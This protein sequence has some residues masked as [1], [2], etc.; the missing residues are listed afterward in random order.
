MSDNFAQTVK[1]QADIVRIIGDYIKL[2]KSGAQNYTGLCPFHKEK[3][4]SFSVNATHNYFYCF[5]CHEKGDVFTFVMKLENI[6]F[7]E[8]IRVVATKCGIPLPKRE[9]NSPDEVREAGIRRQLTDIH[10][11]ATQYFEAALKAPEAARAREYLTGRGVTAETIAKF[12]IGYAPDD[13]NHMREQLAKH[14]PDE[15]LRASGLFS[16]K[17]QNDGSQGQLYARFRKRITFPIANE[18]GKTIAFTARALDAED[19]KGRPIAKYLNSPETALYSKGQ[20]LFNLDKAKADIRALGFA[21]LVEGQMD[22]ISVYMA[23]IKGVL[24]TSGTAFTEMQIR[25]LS[26]FTKRVIVNFDPDTA[27]TAATEK[28]IALLTEEDFEV[29]IVTLEG[30]LDP[31]RFIREQGV[32]QY[33]A[34][35]RDAKR[36]SDYLIDRAREQFPTRTPEGKVKA[37]NFLLPHIRRM[38]SVRQREEFAVD[39]AQKLGISFV[40]SKELSDAASKKVESVSAHR[41]EPIDRNEEILLRV[42]VLPEN[43]PARIL[44][45]EQLTQHPEWYD[46]LSS[47]ALLESLANAPAPPNPLDAAPD[48]PSR[49][50]LARTLQNAENPDSASTNAQSMTELVENALETLKC[51]Q[52]ERRQRELRTLIAEADRHGDHEMLTKLTAEKLQ[53]DRKLREQ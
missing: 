39:A 26:R 7:P 11:A 45:V 15:V 52:L 31:D 27:G 48:E 6:S 51:R 10:E 28:S 4:G 47:A 8:A 22:C 18:Q 44:A 23:G 41:L 1:Q 24:A 43:D 16:A 3:T 12:R 14:F 9:F 5:G 42:L 37:M 2:R 53:I 33:M 30:G 19:E 13:F 25:L 36:H 17:E 34:A 35:L 29:K 38:P 20:V 32:Q 49:I 21:L 50:L 40:H 46:S